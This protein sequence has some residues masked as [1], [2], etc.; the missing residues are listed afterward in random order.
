MWRQK[1]KDG[2]TQLVGALTLGG[3]INALYPVGSVIFSTD[4]AN[5]GTRFTGTTWAAFGAGRAIVGVGNNGENTYTSEQTFGSDA[6][7][8]T[9]ATSGVNAHT[10]AADPI[11]IGAGYS[12]WIS[13]S[14]SHGITSID[15][16][17]TL[18]DS[19]SLTDGSNAV[20]HGAAS[21][22]TPTTASVTGVAMGGV[23]ANHA[24]VIGA[25]D[26]ASS[27]TAHENRQ[28]SIAVYAWKRTA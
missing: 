4:S 21:G 24:H 17:Q 25:V 9:G 8:L 28:R 20:D 14:H 7:T 12:G 3:V 22:R 23:S 2:T 10:H 5:P 15:M 6:V 11:N 19:A 13:S 26:G 16:Q 18:G 1:Q 27:V